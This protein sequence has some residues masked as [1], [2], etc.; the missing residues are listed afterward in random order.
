MR[1]IGIILI[2]SLL[3]SQLNAQKAKLENGPMLGY[4]TLHEVVIWVQTT[5]AAQVQI[6]YYAEDE[7][8]HFTQSVQT[9]KAD[10]YTAHLLLDEIKPATKY[11][12]DVLIDGKKQKLNF[13]T[14]FV[15]KRILPYRTDPPEFSFAAS[16]G[17]YINEEAFDRPGNEYGGSYQI[18]ETIYKQK[19]DFIIWGGDNVYL[20]QYE[21][22]SWTGVVHR[23]THDRKTPEMQALLANVHNYAV[24]DDHDFGPNDSDAG[25]AFKDMTTRAFQTF[26]ANP[27][28]VAGLESS[29]SFF[30]WYDADF[31]ILDNRYYRSPN[32]L[33]SDDKTQLGEKQLQWLKNA[34][35]FSKASFKFILIGGQFLNAYPSYESYTNYGFNKE[36]EEIIRYIYEQKIKNVV[37]I[38]GDRHYTDLSI[39]KKRGQPD[40]MDI[41]LS[42]FTSGPNT[43][44][45]QEQN[46]LRVEGTTVMERNFGLLRLKGDRK[47]RKLE[48][49]VIGTEGNLIWKKEFSS[50][51]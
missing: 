12:Y 11:N 1:K 28:K 45:L 25:F 30:S 14:S 42:P 36:R 18:F 31:F 44:A 6:E 7:V 38:T 9:Q 29:T 19:P 49:S 35:V 3:Y 10:A 46:F 13:E 21:W 50:E 8:K 32:Y 23:Y 48:I 24:I 41:T 2:M 22:E 37:F 27:P 47:H 39:L 34:L 20:R 17:C 51:R 33:I 40:I 15:S 16:S 26:W 4:S 5:Q 43:H